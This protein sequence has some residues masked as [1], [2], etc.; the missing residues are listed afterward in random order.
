MGPTTVTVGLDLVHVEMLDSP[1][2]C[3]DNL[4]GLGDNT[5]LKGK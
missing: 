3:L 5:W 1:R 4:I 2:T